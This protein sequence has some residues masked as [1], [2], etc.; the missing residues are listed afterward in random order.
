MH[1]DRETDRQTDKEKLHC[2]QRT[3]KA[4][5][6]IKTVRGMLQVYNRSVDP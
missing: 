1:T 6:G 3:T 2:I 4:S 5:H